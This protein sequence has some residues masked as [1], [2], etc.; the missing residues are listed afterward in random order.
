MAAP[1]PT[2]GARDADTADIED[3]ESE[4]FET[5][6]KGRKSRKR[7]KRNLSHESVKAQDSDSSFVEAR[8][9]PLSPPNRNFP[10]PLKILIV[11]IEKT[12]SLNRCPPSKIAKS[13]EMCV[14][15]NSV[16]SIKQLKMESWWNVKI[17]NNTANSQ[18][19]KK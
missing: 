5:V 9:E 19:S 6:I 11:P 17:P 10:N 14:G 16:K 8:T 13:V 4:G 18:T 7:K 12:K 15:N 3:S 1:V 2:L